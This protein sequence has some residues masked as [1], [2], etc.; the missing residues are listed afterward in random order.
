M[1]AVRNHRI[2]GIPL[3]MVYSAGT[4]IHDG[5]DIMIHGLYPNF[6]GGIHE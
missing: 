1:D 6:T 4:R 3:F 5:L 2:F